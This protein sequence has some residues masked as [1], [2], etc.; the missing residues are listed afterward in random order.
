MASIQERYRED[1]QVQAWWGG[2][3]IEKRER[4]KVESRAV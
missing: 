3:G 1:C 2:S 4:E